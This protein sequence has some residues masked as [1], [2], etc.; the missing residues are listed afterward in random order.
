V[1][2]LVRV[3]QNV[4]MAD[5][6]FPGLPRRVP[7]MAS[8]ELVR[9]GRAGDDE[10]VNELFRRY[11]PR[12]QRVVRA[13]M[14]SFLRRHVDAE[15]I[16]QETSIIA[17]EKFDRFEV[18]TSASILAWLSRIAEHVIQN[19]LRTIQ[20]QKRDP[21][22]EVRAATEADSL[23]GV[24]LPSPGPSPSQEFSRNELEALV[25]LCIAEI[26]PPACREV[27]VLRDLC[28]LDWE[29]IRT[30]LDRPSVD[31]VRELYRRA[32][33]KLADRLR[34]LGLAD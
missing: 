17:V 22:R 30:E 6:E 14:S 13:K 31:A 19:K 25:D 11:Q 15:D 24:V 21:K 3:A 29:A 5:Q 7:D 16:V 4:P 2:L 1:S 8:V 9:V 20:A 33:S 27:L 12:L 18:H 10:A 28:G 34:P 26:E 23:S 32:N